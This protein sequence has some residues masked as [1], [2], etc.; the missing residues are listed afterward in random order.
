MIKQ[1]TYQLKKYLNFTDKKFR[2]Q[3]SVFLV[4]LTISLS[5]WLLTN[6]SREYFAYI[7]YPVKYSGIPANKILVKGENQEL[8]LRVKAGGFKIFS[9]DGKDDDTFIDINIDQFPIKRKGDSY[10]V[11]IVTSRLS[12]NIANNLGI[13]DELVSITPDTLHLEFSE[14]VSKRV[15]VKVSVDY[16][17]KKQYQLSN[18]LSVT[19]A[20]V[21]ISGLQQQIDQIDTLFTKNIVFEKLEDS[22][23]FKEALIIPNYKPQIFCQTDSL[24]IIIPVEQFTEAKI[25]IPI[26]VVGENIE[27]RIKTFPEKV[28]IT[29]IVGINNYKKLSPSLFEATAKYNY[30]KQNGNNKL[31]VVINKKPS[32]VKINR[33]VPQHVEY[34]ILKR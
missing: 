5:I 8:S 14:R 32:F 26:T 11:N 30:E 20:E 22:V 34:F 13:K 12:N 10:I 24:N 21:E 15:P 28:E 31:I 23:V 16:T 3:L 7:N 29:C 19:P 2:Y 33:I 17:L 27:G 6:L 9:L 18:S 4:C 25:D 1:K